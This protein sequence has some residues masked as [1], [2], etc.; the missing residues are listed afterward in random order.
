MKRKLYFIIII[1]LVVV[2]VFFS[3][4]AYA[5]QKKNFAYNT[6]IEEEDDD[7]IEND[8]VIYPMFVTIVS[9]IC[10]GITIKGFINKYEKIGNKKIYYPPNDGSPISL[11]YYLKGEVTKK[12]LIASLLYFANEGYINICEHFEKIKNPS[13]EELETNAKKLKLVKI[14]ECEPKSKI[15]KLFLDK[16]FEDSNEIELDTESGKKQIM[17]AVRSV[18]WNL[19]KRENESIVY[20]LEAK[21]R[22]F[23]IYVMIIAILSLMIINPVIVKIGGAGVFILLLLIPYSLSLIAF[24]F[25]ISNKKFYKEEERIFLLPLLFILLIIGSWR[26]YSLY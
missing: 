7:V 12:G 18:Y 4:N 15:E 16:L 19:N 24:N 9:I 5:S 6:L 10:V 21:D 13:F 20:S 17:Y 14:K 11:E 3:V 22:I 23:K 25:A 1:I 8:S 26:I 2:N